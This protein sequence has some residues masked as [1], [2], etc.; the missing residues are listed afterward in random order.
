MS[1]SAA[2]R[3]TW[4]SS[5]GLILVFE[6]VFSS[7]RAWAVC[8]A[9]LRCSGVLDGVRMSLTWARRVASG[10]FRLS[11]ADGRIL[12]RC[13]SMSSMYSAVAQLKAGP[14]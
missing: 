5:V 13:W 11:R 9:A 1:R 14:A 4:T 8:S 10:C 6:L 2:H 7:R 12:G 3:P